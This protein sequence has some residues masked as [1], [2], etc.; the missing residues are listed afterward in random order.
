[1]NRIDKNV[2]RALGVF[3]FLMI[4]ILA[5]IYAAQV[6][7]MILLYICIVVVII[8]SLG[9]LY[10]V[11]QENKALEKSDEE[12]LRLRQREKARLQRWQQVNEDD[13]GRQQRE[14][15]KNDEML[16]R[17]LPAAGTDFEDLAEYTEDV[18][19][20]IARE[21]D[22]V[23]GLIFVL[24]DTDQM[25]H[26]S[27]KY[28]YYSEEKP[29]SFPLGETLSGQVAKNRK[30]LNISELPEDYVTILSG[31]GKSDHC[32]MI[33]APVVWNYKS[34]GIMELASF[35]P[36]SENQ[37]SLIRNVCDSMAQLLNELRS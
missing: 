37:E 22:I 32:H 4:S 12:I 26:I 23:Q 2:T 28:A 35:K 25:F 36:F 5:T 6:R 18:L 29:R 17:I 10:L 34:I 20:N 8:L 3:A 16:A 19:Q 11:L 15:F 7:F 13:E 27:G 9:L 30:M 14:I 33:I 21:M 1:M 24:S 31:L